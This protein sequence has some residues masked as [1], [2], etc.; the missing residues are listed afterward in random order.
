[1]YLLAGLREN[2]VDDQGMEV[3]VRVERHTF[4]PS[5]RTI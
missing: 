2:A 4:S 5:G 1:M 3:D